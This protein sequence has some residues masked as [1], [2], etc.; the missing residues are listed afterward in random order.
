[1]L[2]CLWPGRLNGHPPGAR[3]DAGQRCARWVALFTA[4]SQRARNDSARWKTGGE[5]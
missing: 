5:M 3:V 2:L 1:M 4:R